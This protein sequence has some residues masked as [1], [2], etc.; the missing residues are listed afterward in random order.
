ME[1]NQTDFALFLE[2]WLINNT[3]ISAENAQIVKVAILFF[4]MIVV[5]L[6]LWWIGQWVINKF[7]K[8]I[9]LKTT[10]AWDDVLLE[11]GVFKKL[12]HII[13]ISVISSLTPVVFTDYPGYIPIIEN[14]TSILMVIFIIRLAVALINSVGGFFALSPKFEDKPIGSFTQLAKIILWSVGIV[15]LIS[16]LIGKNPLALFTALGAVSAVLL[17]IFKDTILGFMASIQLAINDMVRIG[18]WVSMPK[19][20]ADGNVIE[21]NLTTIKVKNWDNTVSTVPTYAF[22]NDSFTNYRSM[23]EGGGRR[24]MRS[25]YFKIASVKFCDEEMLERYSKLSLVREHIK[26]KSNEIEEYN[27]QRQ[28]ETGTSIANGRRMTNLGVFRAYL[29]AYIKQ[30]PNINLDMTCMVRQLQADEKGV[31]LQVYCFS[32]EKAWVKYE[33]IQGDIFDH[34]LATVPQFDLEVF[35]IP[36]SADV[37]ALNALKTIQ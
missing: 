25:I 33:I 10:T 12:G 21:I 29:L 5:A 34:V 32:K 4:A 17:L 9:V 7:V 8:R 26:T 18:D 31:P 27:Q 16:L 3:G 20:G 36:A 23:E 15:I 28:I 11:N 24:I 13:P 14:I 6:L 22:V 30:N 35:E 37:R 1:N 2:E 19:Y